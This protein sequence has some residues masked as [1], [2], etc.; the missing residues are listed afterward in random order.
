MKLQQQVLKR[1]LPEVRLPPLR[2]KQVRHQPRI[3][4]MLRYLIGYENDALRQRFD[5]YV[6]AREERQT[7]GA[8]GCFFT[9]LNE[10]CGFDDSQGRSSGSWVKRLLS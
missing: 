7:L 9:A 1:C 6:T 10:W 2:Q 3:D 8:T 4:A 5:E